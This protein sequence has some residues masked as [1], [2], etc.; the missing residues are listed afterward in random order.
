MET[1]I[2]F[3]SSACLFQ[4]CTS[5][6]KLRMR[7]SISLIR[8]ALFLYSASQRSATLSISLR[9]LPNFCAAG[10]AHLR[11]RLC[12][13]RRIVL[14]R[15]RSFWT[16]IP[17][18]DMARHRCG[19]FRTMVGRSFRKHDVDLGTLFLFL[20]CAASRC[21]QVRDTLKVAIFHVLDCECVDYDTVHDAFHVTLSNAAAEISF[22]TFLR[23]RSTSR[24]SGSNC[25]GTRSRDLFR[26]DTSRMVTSW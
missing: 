14:L 20:L 23:D 11:C 9:Q 12:T 22:R 15:I 3:Q 2:D 6:S 1:H 5:C 26:V 13:V 18:V 24:S 16:K 17:L 19:Y 7:S 25:P 21:A 8:S 10:D 4:S